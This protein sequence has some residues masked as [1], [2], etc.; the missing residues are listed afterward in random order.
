[1]IDEHG[2]DPSIVKTRHYIAPRHAQPPIRISYVRYVAEGP[3]CG[4]F[5]T[6]LA[7]QPDNLNSE[8]FGCATQK[9]LAAMV[10]NPADL[11]EPRTMTPRSEERRR[12]N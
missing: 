4:D 11:V 6:N 5:P 9:N 2:F 1:M 7:S 12:T 10:A 8:N 3:Q